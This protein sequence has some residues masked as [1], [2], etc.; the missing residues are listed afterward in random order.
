MTF[1]IHFEYA[2]GTEDSIIVTGDTIEDIRSEA[3]RAL[4]LRGATPLF[5]EEI[6]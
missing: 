6:E 3:A 4:A 1:R 5:S 2:D